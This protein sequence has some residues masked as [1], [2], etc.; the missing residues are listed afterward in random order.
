MPHPFPRFTESCRGTV[1]CQISSPA[2][3]DWLQTQL[4]TLHSSFLKTSGPLK[5]K[6]KCWNG[7]EKPKQTT[8]C[9]IKSKMISSGP[10]ELENPFSVNYQGLECRSHQRAARQ[11]ARGWVQVTQKHRSRGELEHQSF[12]WVSEI[13]AC[14]SHVAIQK[15]CWTTISSSNRNFLCPFDNYLLYCLPSWKTREDSSLTQ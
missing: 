14:L 9:V 8:A 12:P 10:R 3:Q 5:F 1:S 6:T 15:G 4:S 2:W 13:Q 7:E 11:L